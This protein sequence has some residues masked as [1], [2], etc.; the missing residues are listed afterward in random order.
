MKVVILI[1][2][3]L[4]SNLLAQYSNFDNKTKID[5]NYSFVESKGKYGIINSSNSIIVPINYNQ[6]GFCESLNA[7][8]KYVR[9]NQNN[10]W[11]IFDLETSKLIIPIRYVEVD[12]FNNDIARVKING[13]Y[14]YVNTK[15]KTTV[16]YIYDWA[17]TTFFNEG[18]ARVKSDNKY[19]AINGNN[20]II[21]PIVYD[22][23][24]TYFSEGLILVEKNHKFGFI[25]EK[26]KIILTIKY[27]EVIK[28]FS[29]G[30]AS[31]KINNKQ[32]YIDKKG[33]EYTTYDEAMEKISK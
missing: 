33:N 18:I 23:I 6:I 20:K 27:D 21:I 15:G 10:K 1:C 11:G 7:V 28:T 5:E 8:K 16:P 19:G 2:I 30:I 13:K 17:D 3:L 9:V 12:C 24:G 29:Q 22:W 26:G 25:D 32:I 4:S 31:V 14:G